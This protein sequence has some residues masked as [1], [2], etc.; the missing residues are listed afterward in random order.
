VGM[1]GW[2]Q[3]FA[4]NGLEGALLPWE[5]CVPVRQ[6]DGAKVTKKVHNEKFDVD[7]IAKSSPFV[8]NI[9]QSSYG[10]KTLAQVLAKGSEDRVEVGS[11][12]DLIRRIAL[13]GRWKDTKFLI[14]FL[15]SSCP[16]SV[17]LVGVLA[18]S[19]RRR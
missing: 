16:N 10:S 2:L 7:E 1:K 5:R 4:S 14:K 19:L 13:G 8:V 9:W 17:E 18:A 6:Q 12:W 11:T 15:R 3:A